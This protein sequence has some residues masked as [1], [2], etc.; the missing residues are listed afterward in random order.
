MLDRFDQYLTGD[1]V[2]PPWFGDDRFHAAHRSNLLR[3]SPEHYRQY[4]PTEPDDLEYV[5]PADP[6]AN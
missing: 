6:T 2:M 1:V 4:W 5:W 3:K